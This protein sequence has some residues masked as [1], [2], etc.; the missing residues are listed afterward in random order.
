M[1]ETTISFPRG[2]TSYQTYAMKKKELLLA[3]IGGV[4]REIQ[5][6]MKRRRHRWACGADRGWGNHIDGCIGEFALA[7][8]LDRSWSPGIV[9][10]PDLACGIEVRASRHEKASLILHPSDHDDK[11]YVLAWLHWEYVAIPGWLWGKEGKRDEYWRTEGVRY[12]AY[13]IAQARLRPLDDLR[14]ELDRDIGR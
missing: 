3:A 11:I 14:I 12:P 4:T 2:F 10:A 9:G 8:Q 1:P 6:M 5:D 13:F 7:Q